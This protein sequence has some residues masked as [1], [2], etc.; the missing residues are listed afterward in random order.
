M[1]LYLPYGWLASLTEIATEDT[2]S[3]RPRQ[4]FP[5]VS[6]RPPAPEAT[7]APGIPPTRGPVR[8]DSPPPAHPPTRGDPSRVDHGQGHDPRTRVIRTKREGRRV[9]SRFRVSLSEVVRAH[10]V[11]RVWSEPPRTGRGERNG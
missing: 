10:R 5:G 1:H 2:P 3:F 9:T 8:R 11:R 7:P 6:R 4:A